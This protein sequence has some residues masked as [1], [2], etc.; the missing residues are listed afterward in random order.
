MRFRASLCSRFR[1]KRLAAPSESWFRLRSVQ[2]ATLAQRSQPL[3]QTRRNSLNEETRST[4]RL[5]QRKGSLSE[6]ARSAKR[7]VQRRS[8]QR[9]ASLNSNTTTIRFASQR[10]PVVRLARFPL[11]LG[12]FL[13]ALVVANSA[14]LQTSGRRGGRGGRGDS[15]KVAVAVAIVDLLDAAAAPGVHS[16]GALTI[17][18]HQEKRNQ[19]L[20]ERIKS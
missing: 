6:K 4:K 1:S 15:A 14:P 20:N 17:L 10:S 19:H 8:S 2:I 11:L 9:T 16:Q 7:P 13:A 12:F 3:T 18:K 5:A